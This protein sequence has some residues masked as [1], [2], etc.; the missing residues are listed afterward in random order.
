MT[1]TAPTT[2]EL[3]SNPAH[4]EVTTKTGTSKTKRQVCEYHIPSGDGAARG[5]SP[6]HMRAIGDWGRLLRKIAGM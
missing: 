6:S 4:Y 2:C 1:T 5:N 3:C